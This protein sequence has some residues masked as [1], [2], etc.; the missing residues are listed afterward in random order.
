MKKSVGEIC[1]KREDSAEGR[2][3]FWINKSFLI[4]VLLGIFLFGVMGCVSA[5][6]VSGCQTISAE[7]HYN[8][9]QNI[10]NPTADCLL[11]TSDNVILDGNGF[12]IVNESF[13]SRAIRVKAS[14]IIIKNFNIDVDDTTGTNG[15][16]VYID[17]TSD[18]NNITVRDSTFSCG[19]CLYAREGCSNAE[20]YFINNTFS[21]DSYYP[22]FFG[23]DV[24]FMN[25]SGN[26]FNS[27]I[28]I[29]HYSGGGYIIND[30][31]VENND[32]YNSGVSLYS[33]LINNYNFS[34]NRIYNPTYSILYTTGSIT[35]L[36]A[37]ENYLEDFTGNDYFVRNGASSSNLVC[38]DNIIN[39]SQAAYLFSF[40]GD[41]NDSIIEGNT[42]Y[43]VDQTG[44]IFYFVT[45][46]RDINISN[47]TVYNT[48]SVFI[49]G[50]LSDSK[51]NNNFLYDASDFGTMMIFNNS[52]LYGNR[53]IPHPTEDWGISSGNGLI[54]RMGDNS[55]IYNNT[56]EYEDNPQDGHGFMFGGDPGSLRNFTI[57]DNTAKHLQYGF[58]FHGNANNSIMR[59]N[60]AIDVTIGTYIITNP[61]NNRLYNMTY[62]NSTYGVHFYS[63]GAYGIQESPSNNT[64]D[65]ITTIN[66]TYPISYTG[67]NL[68]N[69]NLVKN[70]VADSGTINVINSYNVFIEDVKGIENITVEG[71]F[72]NITLTNVSYNNDVVSS[73]LLISNFYLDVFS[74]INNTNI[75][76]INSTGNVVYSNLINGSISQQTLLSYENIGGTVTNYS[77]YT[78]TAS[79]TG[80]HSQNIDI[81][82]TDNNVTSF[83]LLESVVP[84]I[85]LISPTNGYS[86]TVSSTTINFQFNVSDDS[87][88][89]NCSVYISE[90]GYDNST[91]I[92]KSLTN[93]ISASLSS[94]S[95]SWYVNCTDNIGNEGNSS[96]R[97]FTITAPATTSSSS[98]GSPSFY[99][100]QSNLKDG[101]LKSMGRNWKLKFD[102]KNESHEL[103]L[104]K[105][106]KVNKTA[107]VSVSSEL[108]TKV[109]SVGEEWKVDLDNDDFY[110]LL[111]RLDNVTLFRAD[112]FVMEI[113]ESIFVD[114]ISGNVVEGGESFEEVEE[115]I[116]YFWVWV[117]G[118]IVLVLIVVGILVFVGLKVFRKGK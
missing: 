55:E 2:R 5:V 24:S 34:R 36:T 20:V 13:T 50:N 27:S 3:G 29:Y 81:N 76:I 79:A 73:G 4:F 65:G 56:I 64:V 18:M 23:K 39:G 111:V 116:G 62:I 74:N 112:I 17:H 42:F 67:V 95:Y 69:G 100:T 35:N 16:G 75:T 9:I 107:T 106:D 11:I 7:G 108:Q 60:T 19:T 26:F 115:E 90:T 110:D 97:S 38:R 109:L 117:V 21:E 53:L 105:I 6:D 78:I 44:S 71:V 52:K 54:I 70:L 92:N 12:S 72:S 80:Y 14:N 47:N 31:V 83:T 41:L 114:V 22:I 43:N 59:N 84:N 48:T 15:Y 94:G 58:L 49:E 102:V 46:G 8:L 68:T 57:Y 96:S 82:L 118:V 63:S 86:I 103:K 1:L 37:E 51:I 28:P 61:K 32:F 30:L 98:G 85:T 91:A 113:D 99:P 45:M 40:V 93:T 104:N 89:S 33:I 101:Y 77:N 87:D 25:I 66:V 88:I 10:T